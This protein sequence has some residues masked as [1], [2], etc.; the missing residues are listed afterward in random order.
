MEVRVPD[1]TAIVSESTDAIDMCKHEG[2]V[3]G[4]IDEEISLL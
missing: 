2:D 4:R 3:D 1:I